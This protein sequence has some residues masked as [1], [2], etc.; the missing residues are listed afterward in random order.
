M[1]HK[2]IHISFVDRNIIISFSDP[3]R[4]MRNRYTINMFQIME[5]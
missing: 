1:I 3:E 2:L 5:S 4:E